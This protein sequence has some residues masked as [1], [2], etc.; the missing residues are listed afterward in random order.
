MLSTASSSASRAAVPFASRPRVGANS[1]P[2]TP[3]SRATV[4]GVDE[5]RAVLERLARIERLDR[6][7]ARRDDLLGEL[8]AL[9]GEAEAWSR[10]EGGDSGERAVSRLRAALTE[11]SVT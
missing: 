4:G 7:G 9:L 1:L 8:R 6:D 11:T 5:A 3:R 10:M 2:A